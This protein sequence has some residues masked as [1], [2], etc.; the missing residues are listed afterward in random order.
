MQRVN[1]NLK[2]TKENKLKERK[3]LE[4]ADGANTMILGYNEQLGTGHFCSL[5]PSKFV[6]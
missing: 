4:A 2:V 3:I 6:Y 5:K 1:L